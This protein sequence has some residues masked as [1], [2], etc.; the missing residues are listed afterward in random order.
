MHGHAPGLALGQRLLAIAGLGHGQLQRGQVPFVLLAQQLLA[1]GHRIHI[2]GMGRLVDQRLHHEGG[3][4]G[5][6]GAPPQHGYV[7]LDVMYRQVERHVVRL[8][9]ALDHG[10]VDPVLDHHRLERRAADDGLA[11]DG[12]VPGHDV[13]LCVQ[14]QL[15][16]VHMCRAVVA[17]ADVV[18]AAPDHLDRTG[19]AGRPVSLGHVN[20]FHQIVGR[21]HGA[22]AKAAAGHHRMQ[23]HLLRLE[24]GR[25]RDGAL[26]YGLELAAGP[27]LATVR[28]QVHHAVERLH[29][30]V[31][32]VGEFVDGRDLLRRARQARRVGLPGDGA[33]RLRQRLVV[34]QLLVAADFFDGAGI[35][36]D[37]QRIAALLGRP[38]AVRDHGHAAAATV[39]RHFQHGHHAL[40]GLGPGR[41]ELGHFGAK[42][43]RV[44]DQRHLGAGRLEVHAE[45]LVAGGLGA[46]I[47]PL[48]GL[49]DQAELLRVLQRHGG[50]HR[51]LHGRI[52]HGAVAGLLAGGAR[53]HAVG[54]LDLGRRHLPLLGGGRHQH[55][56]GPGADFAV[57]GKRVGDG[58]GTARHLDAERG[59]LVLL[60]GRGQLAAHLRP[61]GIKLLGDQHRQRRLHALAEFEPVDLHRYAVVRRNVEEGI[62]LVDLGLLGLGVGE[63]VRAGHEKAQHQPAA[64]HR[65]RLDETAPAHASALVL[66]LLR[67]LHGV[68]VKPF[69]THDVLL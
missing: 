46:R 63:A 18:L 34:G 38:V 26:V 23:H 6:D 39:G 12:M 58:A 67:R 27:Y 30:R 31:R 42:H 16:A 35:P 19:L 5:T 21:G 57:L 15:G 66:V 55:G 53:Q 13:A 17:A 28:A 24:A 10:G 4:G 2:G 40:D 20:R 9:H 29:G 62:R 47:E 33:R 56:A 69:D 50:G 65:P 22:P 32:Q 49:A 45:L 68:L 59:V 52:G 14:P 25:F 44:G 7:G 48:D 64:G 60:A 1:V 51:L 54:R 41:V 43:G 11:H 8:A 61:V 37:L 3:M 36:V